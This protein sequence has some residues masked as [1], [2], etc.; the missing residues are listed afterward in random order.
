[1]GS[2]HGLGTAMGAPDGRRVVEASLPIGHL[3]SACFPAILE[4]CRGM[5]QG[6]KAELALGGLH[7]QG[8]T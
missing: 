7:E 8:W 6:W 3:V 2:V 4:C 5:P 1:M